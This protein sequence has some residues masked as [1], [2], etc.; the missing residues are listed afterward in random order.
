[1]TG[2][3]EAAGTVT[4]IETSKGP[5]G[6]AVTVAADVFKESWSD[7]IALSQ[8][9][10]SGG[11]LLTGYQ[12]KKVQGACLEL[13]FFA[14]AALFNIAFT[15][16]QVIAIAIVTIVESIV[17]PIVQFAFH[18]IAGFFTGLVNAIGVVGKALFAGINP[19]SSVIN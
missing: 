14:L 15:A 3:D 6:E 8:T 19:S 17:V 9:S 1:M 11:R 18:M 4:Y 12:A 2:I 16:V 10:P 5:S 13:F 7:R